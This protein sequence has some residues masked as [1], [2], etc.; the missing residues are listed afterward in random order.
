MQEMIS[1]ITVEINCHHKDRVGV[2]R[3]LT[4]EGFGFYCIQTMTLQHAKMC[5]ESNIIHIPVDGY[6]CRGI[7]NKRCFSEE[8]I[9][10]IKQ[11]HRLNG[12]CI[13]HYTISE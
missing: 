5:L 12:G 1:F 7:L 10:Y 6:E 9:A 4:K 11:N 8:L 3:K 13:D 2:V